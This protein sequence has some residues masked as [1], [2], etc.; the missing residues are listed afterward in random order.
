MLI[1]STPDKMSIIIYDHHFDKVHYALV[2]AAAAAAIGNPVTLF[3]TMGASQALLKAETN[4][5]SG[6]AKMPL[7]DGYGTGFERDQFYKNNGI[8][9]FEEL[10]QACITLKV[11][12][13]VCEMGLQAKGIKN[14]PLR[15]D[16]SIEVSGVV[17]FL[18]DAS[19]NG[20]TIFI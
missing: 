14:N 1:N 19:S 13:M 6:W 12:F 9:H 15:T 4:A 3:F 7:S 16:L 17:T 10:L 18:N 20:V 11:K 5:L 2:M 8:A